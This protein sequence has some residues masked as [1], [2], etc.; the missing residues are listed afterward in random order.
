MA[1]FFPAEIDWGVAVLGVSQ[2]D[3]LPDGSREG[4]RSSLTTS[5][6]RG[7]RCPRTLRLE[8]VSRAGD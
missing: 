2:V 1:V 8:R 7:R 4:S 5:A 3:D 6:R